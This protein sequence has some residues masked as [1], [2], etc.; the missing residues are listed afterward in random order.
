MSC[1]ECR[2]WSPSSNYRLHLVVSFCQRALR[3]LS[4]HRSHVRRTSLDERLLFSLLSF[5][6]DYQV[7]ETRR[8]KAPVS[9]M[10]VAPDRVAKRQR[11]QVDVL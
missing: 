10:A 8:S 7:R 4:S 9:L 2:R 3:V 6:A 11:A 5:L 1:W